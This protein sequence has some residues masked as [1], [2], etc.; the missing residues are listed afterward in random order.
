MLQR[1]QEGRLLF[2]WKVSAFPTLQY[3]VWNEAYTSFHCRLQCW[4]LPFSLGLHLC[5][6]GLC[7]RLRMSFWISFTPCDDLPFLLL[8]HTRNKVNIFLQELLQYTVL[9]PIRFVIC[10]SIFFLFSSCCLTIKIL[11]Y[12]QLF[13]FDWIFKKNKI[14][15]LY[16]V[17]K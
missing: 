13:V 5:W 10:S 11:G 1:C 4:P 9:W 3:C 14:S 15:H 2:L 17:E 8:L 6:R 12:W 16:Q 7:A